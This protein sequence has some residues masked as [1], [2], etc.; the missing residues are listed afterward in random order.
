VVL[1]V[2]GDAGVAPTHVFNG[3]DGATG[4]YLRPPMTTRQLADLVRGVPRDEGFVAA[5]KRWIRSLT[6]D[7]L[8][9]RDGIDPKDLSQAG[10]GVVF[11]R[12]ENGAVREAL[13]DLLGH[14]RGQAAGRR[15]RFYR[16]FR[17]ED[18]YRPGEEKWQFLER[19]GAGFGPA[20][21]DNVPYYL[22]LVGDPETIPFRFQYQ[23]D[24][25]YAVGRLCFETLDEYA[26]YARAVV[27]AETRD[28]TAGKEPSAVFF[29]VRNPGDQAT[30][31][32][33]DF[34]VEPLAERAAQ[35]HPRWQVRQ[36]LAGDATKA[37]LAELLGGEATPSLLFAASH[38]LAFPHGSRRQRPHQGAVL[39]QD[40]PGPREWPKPIP[41]DFY[42]SA[43]DLDRDA[44]LGGLIA[45]YFGCYGGGTTRLEDYAFRHGRDAAAV[46][47]H[48]FVARL[49][50]RL[51]GLARGGALAV[52]AHVE[53]CWGYSFLGLEGG[54][55]LVAFEDTLDR[56]L[57]G[58]PVGSA[59]EVVNRRYAELSTVLSEELKQ[60]RYGKQVDEREL[61]RLWTA[62]NDARSYVVLGDPAVRLPVART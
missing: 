5:L 44:A 33:A 25:E 40:W 10:W 61:V 16:E 60:A 62:E 45:F 12:D 2:P 46:A 18:G 1:R 31:Q 17:G 29:G 35:R 20:D 30:Q 19:H 55:R 6:V 52:I 51:L 24:V 38:G 9:P 48:D 59:M 15:E 22:L 53:Q 11:P 23:L 43:D 36:A 21:P 28:G 26:A 3:V 58:H 49:P 54:E 32:S 47:P 34:L 57:S 7:R 8:G 42:F 27:A 13:G 4:G 14:R 37:R 56:L 50:Q 39:C 41:P